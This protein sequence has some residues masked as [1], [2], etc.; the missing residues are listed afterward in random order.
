MTDP[1]LERR[2]LE[3]FEAELESAPAGRE[4]RLEELRA[5]DPALAARVSALLRADAGAAAAVPTAPAAL[6]TTPPEPP[7]ER[8]GVWRLTELLGAGGMGAVWRGVRD[9]GL[10]D[11][12][13]AV[14]LVRPGV[15]GASA[16]AQFAVERRVL[17]RL[18]HPNIAA[19]YDGGADAQGRAWFAMELVEGRVVTEAAREQPLRARVRL[20]LAVCGAVQHAHAALVVHADIKPGNI[21]VDAEGRPKLLDFG[22]GRSLEDMEEGATGYGLTAP[23]ASPARLAGERPVPADDVYALGAL[24]WELVEG[25]PPAATPPAPATLAPPE[26]AAAIARATDPDP[27]R[28][29]DGAGALAEDLR[30]WLEG[31]PVRALPATRRRAFRL[32]VHR[33]PRVLGAAAAGVAGL[34]VALVVITGLYQRSEAERRQA[35]LRF[36]QAR[37]MAHYMLFDLFDRLNDA[38][39]TLPVRRELVDR[40]RGYLDD[41]SAAPRAPVDVR[42]EA[43]IG[44]MQLAGVQGMFTAGQL[45]ERGRGGPPLERAKALLAEASPAARRDPRWL[46][47]DGRL[48]LF[49]GFAADDQGGGEGR[50]AALLGEAV[51]EL[52]AASRA[53]PDDPEAAV[54]LWQARLVLADVMGGAKDYARETALAR[55]ALDDYARRRSLYD[56]HP[57]APL[58]LARTY[59]RLGDSEYYRGDKAAS[60][61][62]YGRAL[63]ILQAED[64][65]HPRRTRTLMEILDARWSLAGVLADLGQGARAADLYDAALT[66]GRARLLV[67]PD[68]DGLQRMVTLIASDRATLLSRLGRHTEAL[69]AVG[70]SLSD[71]RALYAQRPD[72]Q[73]AWRN[74]LNGLLPAAKVEAAAGRRAEACG[75][76]REAT[77][78]FAAYMRRFAVAARTAGGDLQDIRAADAA[79]RA[80][81][82]LPNR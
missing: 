39:G 8:V 48:K 34:V 1:A 47:A 57:K 26:L 65:R 73:V 22:I 46:H 15:F 77:A 32:F 3:A 54:D 55:D 14:K 19:L 10:F 64:A 75:H 25:A 70:A 56:R 68:H 78:G 41:L 49:E 18:R 52:G 81:G 20:L 82:P 44:Y 4:A 63:A 33:H 43:A 42:A 21:L 27:A 17:A 16:L 37:G 13:V 28:R 69:A 2:A 66:D 38:P 79:C 7:P 5:T 58:F 80:G 76:Y 72:D 45:G 6:S 29:Y 60:A 31:R 74:Y 23:Y 11:Q 24:L 30:L 51:R 35:D 40:A 50:A 62:S 36:G 9:D 61:Q 12:T 59:K 67:E 71:R 53:L